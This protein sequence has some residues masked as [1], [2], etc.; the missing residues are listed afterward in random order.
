VGAGV[1]A[2]I[3]PTLAG[4]KWVTGEDR[5]RTQA[6]L[7]MRH[8]IEDSDLA[9]RKQISLDFTE[10]ECAHMDSMIAIC[11]KD[12]IEYCFSWL[13]NRHGARSPSAPL[14]EQPVSLAL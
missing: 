1:A 14:T 7:D 9:L 5:G 11:M 6:D 4:E 10:P 13:L 8:Y 2:A 3:I 12:G